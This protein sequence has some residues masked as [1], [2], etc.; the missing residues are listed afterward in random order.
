MQVLKG[1][2]FCAYEGLNLDK[3]GYVCKIHFWTFLDVK[4][5]FFQ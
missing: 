2:P 4:N 5:I 3:D 1:I